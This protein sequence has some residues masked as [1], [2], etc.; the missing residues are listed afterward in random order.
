MSTPDAI[1]AQ[2]GRVISAVGYLAELEGQNA[3]W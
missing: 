2:V 3:R 1:T